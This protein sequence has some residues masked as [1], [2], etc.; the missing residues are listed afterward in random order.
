MVSKVIAELKCGKAADIAGL[1]A[2]HLHYSHPMLSVILSKFFSLN[3]DKS[4]HT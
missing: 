4:L 2:E 3:T 1:T